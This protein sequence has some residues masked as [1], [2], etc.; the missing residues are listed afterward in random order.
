MKRNVIVIALWS[1]LVLSIVLFCVIY[2][3]I[4]ANASV[5]MSI[6]EALL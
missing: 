6:L 3:V 5:D 4:K 2:I 1:A